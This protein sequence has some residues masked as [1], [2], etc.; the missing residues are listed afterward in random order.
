LV[1]GAAITDEQLAEDLRRLGGEY[2]IGV[3]TLGVQLEALDDIVDAASI[4][5]MEDRAFENLQGRLLARQKITS[6]RPSA[7]LDWRLIRDMRREHAEF[8]A[9]FAWIEQCLRDGTATPH[10]T[11]EPAASGL[12]LVAVRGVGLPG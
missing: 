12:N 7:T 5:R 10:G 6:A 3:S 8:H 1:I 2:G 9:F 4:A 11:P